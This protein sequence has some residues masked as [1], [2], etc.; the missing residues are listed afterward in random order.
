MKCLEV[1][2]KTLDKDMVQGYKRQ[3]VEP[4]LVYI[5]KC[6]AELRAEVMNCLAILAGA[7]KH[8]ITGYADTIVDVM[9]Q[10]WDER[11]L[12]ASLALLE[13]FGVYM[14]D[15][16]R[17]L[18]ARVIRPFVSSLS[19][20]VR[21]RPKSITNIER[22]LECI[23]VLA[24]HLGKY[25]HMI[26]PTLNYL[27]EDAGTTL[28]IGCRYIRAAGRIAKHTDA[29]CCV[30]AV[31]VS[32]L[33]LVGRFNKAPPQKLLAAVIET[34]TLFA[35]YAPRAYVPF[36]PAV[37]RLFAR[38][39]VQNRAYSDTAATLL[40][41]HALGSVPTTPITPIPQSRPALGSDGIADYGDPSDLSA[42]P[43]NSNDNDSNNDGNGGDDG[44]DSYSGGYNNHYYYGGGDG[45]GRRGRRRDDEDEDDDITLRVTP[46]RVTSIDGEA[47]DDALDDNNEDSSSSNADDID[48]DAQDE[49]GGSSSSNNNDS[50]RSK[51]SRKGS[52]AVVSFSSEILHAAW[53]SSAQRF[54]K[55]DW[56]EWLRQYSLALLRDSPSP[57]LRACFALAQEYHPLVQD[58][59]PAAFLSSWD[60]LK[61]PEREHLAAL[62][63]GVLSNPTAPQEV[64]QA[65]LGVL[66][67]MEKLDRPFTAEALFKIQQQQQ[68]Q[69]MMANGGGGGGTGDGGVR[70]RSLSKRQAQLQLQQQQQQQLEN[71]GVPI[72]ARPLAVE[73]LVRASVDC[74][75]YAKALRL[76]EMQYRGDPTN[77]GYVEDLITINNR[78]QLYDASKGV[79]AHAEKARRV[80]MSASLL[81][82]LGEWDRALE[83]H[84]ARLRTAP[85]DPAALLGSLR[86]LHAVGDYRRVAAVA[87]YAWDQQDQQRREVA[88]IAV[89]AALATESWDA[90][91]LYVKALP[92]ESVLHG[93]TQAALL[94]HTR[95]FDAAR[96]CVMRARAA[97][98][99][100]VAALV[101]E[102]YERAYPMIVRAQQLAELEQAID[103]LEAP[104]G[105]AGEE[106]R[107][108]I[109][110]AFSDRL[111]RV[112]AYEIDPWQ[113]ILNV[114]GL[115]IDKHA[116]PEMWIKFSSLCRKQGRPALAM[117][118]LEDLARTSM[119]DISR[120]LGRINPR[121]SLAAAKVLW[122]LNE[123]PDE[124]DKTIDFV[125]LLK[126][127][128]A[129]GG[130]GSGA[131]TASG[132]GAGCKDPRLLAKLHLLI[133]SWK[134]ELGKMRG[135]DAAR[136]AIPQA[137]ECFRAAID[138][139]P[140]W[141][142]GVSTWAHFNCDL[143]A[144]C[145]ATQASAGAGGGGGSRGTGRVD[146]GLEADID[147]YLTAALDG[148]VTAIQLMAAE[149]ERERECPVFQDMLRLV[150]LA[151]NH[152]HRECAR[153]IL[154]RAV[155]TLEPE[156]WIK[157]IPELIS[158]IHVRS[159]GTRR[160][161][162]AVVSVL[163]AHH[164][165]AIVHPLLVAVKSRAPLAK[166]LFE[167]MRKSTPAV[168]NQ[169]EVL[170]HELVRLSIN[171]FEM[172][173]VAINDASRICFDESNTFR[174]RQVLEPLF[175][176]FFKGPE[177]QIDKIFIQRIGP[178]V[179]DAYKALTDAFAVVDA[180]AEQ[181]KLRRKM[182]SKHRKAA[183][184]AKD[185]KAVKSK[186]KSEKERKKKPLAANSGR[187]SEVDS[188]TNLD[189]DCGSGSYVSGAGRNVKVGIIGLSDSD[190]DDDNNNINTNNNSSSSGSSG[191]SGS[192]SEGDNDD[193]GDE[194]NNDD[195]DNS[196]SNNVDDADM[197]NKDSIMVMWDYLYA[198][199]NDLERIN[200]SMRSANLRQ[201]A[202]LLLQT[203]FSS[204]CIPGTYSPREAN[205]TITSVA[206]NAPIFTSKQRPRQVL[207]TGSNGVEYQFLLK[208]HEDLRQDERAMQFFELVNTLLAADTATHKDHL[209]IVRYAVVPLSQNT[210]I[211][212]WVLHSNTLHE[213][214]KEYRQLKRT[215][216]EIECKL[217]REMVPQ[218]DTLT[219][220][221]KVEV[222]QYI[223]SRTSGN[224][225]KNI[226]WRRSASSEEW[227]QRRV[228]FT[229]SLAVMSMVGHILGIG[230]RHPSNI[231]LDKDT[232]DVIHIDFGDCF[233]VAMHRQTYPERIPFRLTRMFINAMEV[234]GIEGTF[235]LTCEKVLRV[236]RDNS[237]RLLT[238]LETFVY[239]PLL[240]WRSAS[241]A[242]AAAAAATQPTCK[243]KAG[244][245]ADESMA[246][247]QARLE[248]SRLY[249]ETY[250]T[251]IPASLSIASWVSCS[252]NDIALHLGNMDEDA[253]TEIRGAAGDKDARKNPRALSMMK[254][255]ANK[256]CG[257]E[258]HGS[259][260]K[261]SVKD[262]VEYLIQKATDP[263]NIAA[264]F[265]GWCPFW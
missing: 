211:I 121:I 146:A 22:Y 77:M 68:L 67:F 239:D 199:Y 30:S 103:Y 210:G 18:L 151:F 166:T 53:E 155:R 228:R 17:E 163:C 49:S 25:L 252:E 213:L 227:L 131:A 87:Q 130:S 58:L 74:R 143:V 26:F 86:C 214:I 175:A 197:V 65:L 168:A 64:V 251:S 215:L 8:L 176:L 244:T 192:D 258:I 149:R 126:D 73:R 85:S 160:F 46:I 144:M 203:D 91:S 242:T 6:R 207:L 217:Q 224:D 27:L 88:E 234:S 152:G 222:L 33:N 182:R 255:V 31:T 185:S 81:E 169:A 257:M 232:G 254:R 148:L 24:P 157:V 179:R 243:A 1:V 100:E 97:L 162:S 218:Y 172:W 82:K 71:G 72:E 94:V 32:V 236:L 2:L 245:G 29:G 262:Q 153:P 132:S 191:N 43:S 161:V 23:E 84:E 167:Q 219:A 34:F 114:Q 83:L 10:Y 150:T 225:L 19:V 4:L 28:D 140:Q 20:E 134:Y 55:E 129:S 158:R 102:S 190:S 47:M 188:M 42:S 128:V 238:V 159:E 205:I 36:V 105:R 250:G 212:G 171:W 183:A 174:M 117:Q 208:A 99:A 50:G 184:A 206:E 181:R 118:V 108:A 137:T 107:E 220:L 259:S 96:A 127:V 263:E 201:C 63:D 135:P 164:P 256:L 60:K 247:R 57:P 120:F 104:A 145:E 260:K 133:G 12:N 265:K 230:D 178:K 110:A 69:L 198:I 136:A 138:C 119:R 35:R 79:F 112:I 62:L 59:F 113:S 156:L 229:R 237:E 76:K 48:D 123:K 204:L 231:M 116:H 66:E 264:C 95:E 14:N 216:F 111:R 189:S 90:L 186:A 21:R 249:R 101:S 15:G 98:D 253:D 209:G 193:Y 109:R 173:C 170:T 240:S 115:A 93:V 80:E 45:S 44:G 52:H 106:R 180:A 122:V 61:M 75:A 70:R 41:C 11:T 139:Q 3:L 16:V 246:Q 5:H 261:L 51:R 177:T 196:N 141:L 248:A 92:A 147:P 226:M 89:Q 9:A 38:F 78:L 235:R 241:A 154:D 200:K 7:Y 195:D 125:S 223:L 40:R 142:K 194:D 233:E 39:G 13:Y 56:V 54:T 187:I 202:P 165:H 221:Q 124:F 37:A